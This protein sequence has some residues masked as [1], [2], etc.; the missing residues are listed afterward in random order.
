M[1][2]ASALETVEALHGLFDDYFG[3]GR[4]QGLEQNDWPVLSASNRYFTHRRDVGEATQV[5]FGEGVYPKGILERMARMDFI[6]TDEN[7]VKFY[8]L[9][10]GSDG[11]K[12]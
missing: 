3:E 8:K 7:K 9:I 11:A 2:F 4:L 10:L 12:R 6:H 1:T 5:A